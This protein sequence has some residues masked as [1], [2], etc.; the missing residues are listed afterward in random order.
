MVDGW[1][2]EPEG[3]GA[4][5]HVSYVPATG[6][7]RTFQDEH[8]FVGFGL[9]PKKAQEAYLGVKRA[10]LGVTRAHHEGLGHPLVQVL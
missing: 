4:R 9:A 2:T 8:V 6:L 10:Y 1:R 3:G 7:I 5:H